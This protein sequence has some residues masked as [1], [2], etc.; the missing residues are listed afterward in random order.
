[1]IKTPF[2]IIILL[3]SLSLTAQSGWNYISP[4][5]GS[6]MINP[7]NNIAFRNGEEL[8]FASIESEIISVS[9]TK[10]GNISGRLLLSADSKTLIFLADEKYQYGETISV[11]LK[12]G[13]FTK[14][15]AILEGLSFNFKVK[16]FEINNNLEAYERPEYPLAVDNHLPKVSDEGSKSYSDLIAYGNTALPDNFP[17][18]TILVYN[19]P[20]PEYAFYATEPQTDR[21]GNYAVIL[22]NYGTPVFYREWPSKTVNLQVVANNQ[23]IHKNGSSFLVLDDMYNI[24]D[25]LTA[26]NGYTTNTH[27][28]M[29]LEN[30]NHYLMIY[31]T[32]L[33]GMDTVVPGGSPNA[34]VKGF[35]LQ[36]LDADHNVIFQWR[37]WDHFEITDA[38]NVDLTAQSIDYVHVNAYDTTADGNILL[39]CRHFDEITK[40]DRNTGEIIWRFGPNAQKNMFS[41]S[42]DTVGFSWPHDIQQ[43]EN[44]NLTLYDNGNFHVPQVSR[45][46]EYEIDETNL[47]ATLAWD[48]S[49]DPPFYCMNKGGTRRLTNSNTIVGWGNSW[50]VI[51]T[52]V[53]MDKNVSW[54]LSVDSTLSYRVMK[55]SWKTSFFETSYDTID[56]GYWD[57]YEPV[58]IIV[59][60]TNNADHD[61]SITSASNHLPAFYL[62]TQLPLEIPEGGTANVLVFFFPE[63]MGQQYFND[64][65]TLNYDSYFADTLHQRISRQ[66]VLKGSTLPT[67]IQTLS[68]NEN[69]RVFP[70]PTNGM[71]NLNAD[72]GQ[73]EKVFIYNAQGSLIYYNQEVMKQE[74]SVDLSSSESGVY[75]VKLKMSGSAGPIMLK[76]IK[77]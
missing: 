47:T 3:F 7:E 12:S 56:Y 77:N 25:T 32:Q 28:G 54:E 31:D 20:A 72:S 50:P 73:I 52:E 29:L 76:I 43:L 2:F 46:L 27:D 18:A 68:V 14:N 41:F 69:I 53:D 75:L 60:L 5:P 17:P 45:S 36:E 67:N 61:I 66:I 35:I 57:D 9:G 64:V 4:K 1:M 30:G 62:G 26:G 8:L 74:F 55:F 49:H 42:N 13:V 70:N 40:I 22:D 71:I 23:L 48:Y 44:G 15:G 33:V 6:S 58:P 51:A 21:Y 63:G 65:L 39:C 37:S 10:S 11:S 19:Q 34:T 59:T 24:V 38:N 16:Q